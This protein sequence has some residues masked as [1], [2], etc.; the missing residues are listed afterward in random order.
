MI[1]NELILAG[2]FL[3]IDKKKIKFHYFV[4]TSEKPSVTASI[5]LKFG[6][7]VKPDPTKPIQNHLRKNLGRLPGP[8]N[9]K[10]LIQSVRVVHPGMFGFY[11]YFGFYNFWSEVNNST[12]YLVQKQTPVLFLNVCFRDDLLDLLMSPIFFSSNTFHFY[13][14]FHLPSANLNVNG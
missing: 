12:I 8:V 14:I 2:M 10:T 1:S 6:P 11:L 5:I 9:H 7:G 13:N 3:F 4:F